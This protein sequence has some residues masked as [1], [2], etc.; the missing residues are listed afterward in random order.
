MT[1]EQRAAI[2]DAAAYLREV[3]PIDPAEIHEYVPDRPD[4]DAVHDVLRDLAVNLALIEREDGTFAPVPGEPVPDRG[5]TVTAFPDDAARRL[6]GLLENRFGTDWARSSPGE[7]LRATIRRMKAAYLRGDPVEYD[8][9]L[10]LGYAIYHLPGYFAA[11]QYVL[12][13]LTEAGLLPR[14]VRVVDVGAGV[15]GPALGLFSYVPANSLI[16][17]HAVEPS[18]A[19][20]DVL[21]ALVGTAGRNVHPTIHRRTADQFDP[22]GSAGADGWDL[23]LFANVLSEL[24]DPGGELARYADALAPDGSVIALAPADKQTST[25]LR[26]IERAVVDGLTVYSPTV[27]L[28]PDHEPADRCWSFDARPDLEVPRVQRRLDGAAGSTGEFV[29]V[30]VR[31]S[32]AILRGDGR[33][34]VAFEPDPT[35][36]AKLADA[37]THVGRRI[38]CAGIKLSPNLAEDG[39]PVYLIGDGSQRTDHF[40]VLVTETELNRAITRADYGELVVIEGGLLLWNDDES[41]YNVVADDETVIDRRG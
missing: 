17:Y 41:A 12:D 15:G 11:I 18:D 35:R 19:A 2:R 33:E 21:A 29:N 24:D 22:H 36:F 8:R 38:N 28:W 9:D 3:R 34:R 10:A 14:H 27:R 20:A 30:D 23:V 40:V 32:Y 37:E 6:E 26:T 7:R 31:F 13:D 4:P 1:P 16:E 25:G 39:H 5:S